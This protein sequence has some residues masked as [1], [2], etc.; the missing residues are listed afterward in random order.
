MMASAILHMNFHWLGQGILT[1]VL[2]SSIIM[3]FLALYALSRK[4]MHAALSYAGLCLGIAVYALFHGFELMSINLEQALLWSNMQ[5][6][7]IAS[8][9]GFSSVFILQVTGFGSLL[10]GKKI[11]IPWIIPVLTLTFKLA[12]HQLGWIYAQSSFRFAEGLFIL[13]IVPG[14]WYVVFVVYMNLLLI[15]GVFLLIRSYLNRQAIL[16]GQAITLLAGI[17]IPWI[18]HLVYVTGNSPM[19]L[20]LT[21]IVFIVTGILWGVALFQYKM[22]SLAPM[23]REYVFSSIRDGVIVFDNKD[24]LADI[25]QAAIGIFGLHKLPQAG[26][27]LCHLLSGCDELAL[28]LQ[29]DM[30]ENILN[31]LTQGKKKTYFARQSLIKN[32]QGALMGKVVTLY[33]ITERQ[34]AEQE[35]KK[36]KTEADQ[37]NQA[38]SRFVANMS[39]EVR[40]PMNAIMG[41]SEMLLEEIKEPRHVKM[42]QSVR[43]S[44]KLLL[45]LLN[46]ILDLSKIEAGKIDIVPVPDHL[47]NTLE[48]IRQ[49]YESQA[50][51]KGLEFDIS[52][53]AD[54]PEKLVFDQTRIKQIVF[55][56]AGNAIKFTDKGSVH[57]AVDFTAEELTKG[58]LRI[59]VTDTGIGIKPEELNNIFEPFHQQSGQSNRKY[60]G[61]GLGLSISKGLAERMQG[62][63]EVESTPGKGS[64][65]TLVLPHVVIP[66]DDQMKGHN[67]KDQT[68]RFPVEVAFSNIKQIANPQ[69]LIQTLEKDFLPRWTEV[70]DQLVLF[71]IES[72]V[73]D[74]MALGEKH[75]C[76]P[77]VSYGKLIGEKTEIPDIES[78]NNILAQ[79]PEL[80]NTIKK[81]Y[82]Y[83]AN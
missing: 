49:V 62:S 64:V 57:I 29:S 33:D 2:S 55:N 27:D 43:A 75:N 10:K 19:N 79:F 71:K 77:L 73:K 36:A 50:R 51:A 5:Y 34:R 16:S 82:G 66:D 59:S 44:G 25:N 83:G 12:D 78:I 41:F 21:P 23:A 14:W 26:S 76:P 7:G 17:F 1:M 69:E 52:Y 6:I 18:G 74:I 37:A 39:H 80:S 63:I 60:G 15:A 3:V 65:F 61:T 67:T 11:L 54:M 81:S 24:R 45:S 48:E 47:R 9:V 70:K 53:A 13:N 22:L 56:L 40:T 35:L 4:H 20:D 8:F 32:T 42:L 28:F 58:K 72:F 46:D 68:D 30:D 38:K 31:I